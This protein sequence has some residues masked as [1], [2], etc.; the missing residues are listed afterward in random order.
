MMFESV[1]HLVLEDTSQQIR[2]LICVITDNRTYGH[3]AA[4]I[5]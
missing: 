4:K 2:H 3:T 5:D 1:L